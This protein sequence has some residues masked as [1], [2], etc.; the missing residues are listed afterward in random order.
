MQLVLL[1]TLSEILRTPL[2]DIHH[3]PEEEPWLLLQSCNASWDYLSKSLSLC[4]IPS[5]YYQQCQQ[6]LAQL[7]RRTLK[8]LDGF[9]SEGIQNLLTEQGTW[10]S[11]QKARPETM[12]NLLLVG[13][14]P[15]KW[16]TMVDTR[17]QYQNHGHW[18]ERKKCGLD[19]RSLENCSTPS[20]I[21]IWMS[22][23]EYV[24]FL[25]SNSGCIPGVL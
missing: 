15:S 14:P 7:H 22:L 16:L 6:G 25:F 19:N 5:T 1:L 10:S 13:F 24:I 21:W 3:H 18:E 8:A 9:P 2:E 23:M 11:E 17:K 12:G 20:P 4:F